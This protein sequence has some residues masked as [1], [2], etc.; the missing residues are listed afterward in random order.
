MLQILAKA[1]VWHIDSTFKA[2]PGMW[3]ECF[4]IGASINHRMIV[5]VHALLPGKDSKYVEE[6]LKIVKQAIYPATPKKGKRIAKIMLKSL[7]QSFWTSRRLKFGQFQKYFHQ[8][9]QMDACFIMAN[10]C[11]EI[12]S[13]WGWYKY[14]EKNL[15]VVRQ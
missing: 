5:C 11:F 2:A 7:F 14:M 3:S 13:D 12:S 4:V 8:Q 9:M 6:A 10:H 1:D 15:H